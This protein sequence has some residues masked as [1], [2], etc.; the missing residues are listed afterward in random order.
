[1]KLKDGRQNGLLQT[2]RFSSCWK[3]TDAQYCFGNRERNEIEWSQ[4]KPDLGIGHS[5]ARWKGKR[6][7]VVPVCAETPS[8]RVK[9]Y[10]ATCTT[11]RG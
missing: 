9:P 3:L 6:V 1:M 4:D 5:E 7:K 8:T 10:G 11:Q 2:Y